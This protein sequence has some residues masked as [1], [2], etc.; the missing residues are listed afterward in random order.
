M[1]AFLMPNEKVTLPLAS[2]IVSVDKIE[3]SYRD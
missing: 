2:Y 3:D 1:I